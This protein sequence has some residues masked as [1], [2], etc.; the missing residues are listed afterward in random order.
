MKTLFSPPQ[1]FRIALWKQGFFVIGLHFNNEIQGVFH[2]YYSTF[3]I[4][5]YIMIQ[6]NDLQ[7]GRLHFIDAMRAWAILMMLQGHFVASLLSND[8][9]NKDFFLFS[10]WDYF[11]G[12]TAPVFFAV[13]GFVFTFILLKKHSL[14]IRNPRVKKGF[15]RGLQ[16]MGIGYLLQLN[17]KGLLQGTINDKFYIVHVLQC[18]GLS[19]VLIVIIYLLT[20]KTKKIVFPLILLNISLGLLLFKF[21]LEKW[22]YSFMPT[23]FNNYFTVK[24]GSVFTIIP[25]FAY[26]TFGGFLSVLFNRFNGKKSFYRDIILAMIIIGSILI[27]SSY[28]ILDNNYALARLGDVL[29]VFT[30]FLLFRN[31]L[32]HP[33]LF[34]IGQKTLSLYVVHSIILYG[35]ITGYGLT[36]YYYHSLSPFFVF[37]GV[38]LF[39]FGICSIVLIFKPNLER[40]W[41]IIRQKA[42]F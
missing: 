16:L 20:Y 7:K 13:S 27:F 5:F 33:L 2:T 23:I 10:V 21:K 22:D 11:R 41:R 28:T 4:H 24:N 15:I 29:F 19:I 3:A 40:H 39:I 6:G 9:K 42:L 12:I 34:K 14:G 30:F 38:I 36:R 35:S 17:F 37:F 18:I 31:H 1:L 26:A 32:K 25:W 8:Y